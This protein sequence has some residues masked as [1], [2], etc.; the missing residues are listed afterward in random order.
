MI[1]WVIPQL[2]IAEVSDLD[3]ITLDT[4]TLLVD[5]RL[6]FNKKGDPIKG[7]DSELAI[8]ENILQYNRRVIVFCDG[9]MDR[10]PFIV[11]KVL[12]VLFDDYEMGD[13]YRFIKE[14]RPHIVEHYEWGE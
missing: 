2:A 5:A 13:A 12:C 1:T 3:G 10:S 14:K 7:I 8:V 6:Y 11:A 4:D 9:G